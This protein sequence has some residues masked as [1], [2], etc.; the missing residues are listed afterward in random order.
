LSARAGIHTGEIGSDGDDVSLR[1]A[2]EVAALARPGE[3]LVSRT[4]SDL[5]AGSEIAFAFRG[6]HRLTG[7]SEPWPVF[8]VTGTPAAL[9]R[10]GTSR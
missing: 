3:I 10:D 4:V 9:T 2:A 5:V 6:R 7:I 8:A 1:R